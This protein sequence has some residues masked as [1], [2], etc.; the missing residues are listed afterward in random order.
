MLEY[1][2]TLDYSI[3]A[4]V[5]DDSNLW[6]PSFFHKWTLTTLYV[7]QLKQACKLPLAS[8]GA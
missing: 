5:L 2:F 1:H 8:V 6:L 4:Q 7:L 3:T